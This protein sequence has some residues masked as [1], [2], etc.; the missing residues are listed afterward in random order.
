MGAVDVHQDFT[1]NDIDVLRDGDGDGVGD[2]NERLV[3]TDPDDSA[4]TPGESTVD[5]LVL[6]DKAFRD[7]Y[8]GDPY[9]R[10]HHLV[11]V[12]DEIFGRS[13]TGINLR[14]VG[15][16]E[17]EFR[18]KWHTS[19]LPEWAFVVQTAETHGG[20]MVVMLRPHTPG[21]G[22]CGWAHLTGLK[23]KG[24]MRHAKN[25]GPDRHFV[26]VLGDCSGQVLAHELGHSFG[27]VHSF[28]QNE[29]GTFRWSRGHYVDENDGL[30]IGGAGTTMSY[31]VTYDDRFFDP[32]TRCGEHACGVATTDPIKGADAVRSLQAVRFQVAAHRQAKPDSDGD[33]WVDAVDDAPDDADIWWDTDGDGINNHD[34]ADDDGDGV[35]DATDAFPID[36]TE[37]ADADGDGVGDNADAFPGDPAETKDSNDD[38]I[39]DNSSHE[40]PMFLAGG[41]VTRQGFVRIVNRSDTAGEVLVYAVDDSGEAADTVTLRIGAFEAKHFNSDDLEGGNADKGLEGRTGDGDGD[42]RLVLASRLDLVVTA[43]G[44]FS[45]FLTSL[46]DV[47]RQRE[48]GGPYLVSFFN[49]ASNRNQRSLLRIVNPGDAPAGVTITGTDDRG[50][51][52]AEE[53]RLSVPARQAVVLTSEDLES[54]SDLANGAFG[55][56]Y[57][58]WRL[59]VQADRDI[60]VM[61]L[62]RSPTGHLTNLS[63]EPYLSVPLAGDGVKF[64]LP[65]F[66]LGDTLDP[67]RFAQGFARII[68][69]DITQSALLIYAG[70]DSSGA[71]PLPADLAPEVGHTVHYNSDDIANG[72]PGKDIAAGIGYHDSPGWLDVNPTVEMR[73]LAYFRHK[74]GFLTSMHDRAPATDVC[75]EDVPA[76]SCGLRHDIAVFNPASNRNQRSYLRLLNLHLDPMTV[77]ITGTDD[78]GQV[79]GTV[80]LELPGLSGRMLPATVLESGGDDLT[81]ALGAGYGKW[82]LKLEAEGPLVAMSL[83]RSPSGHWSNLSTIPGVE[84]FTADT[85]SE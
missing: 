2:F 27:L 55:D 18:A 51:R 13:D 60:R 78:R 1:A 15:M 43:Y 28:R 54:G 25:G 21:T 45:G 53:V 71:S 3:G 31:G 39:G 7:L 52:S 41:D 68:H 63:T 40:V 30:G 73:V 17:T 50:V 85:R 33:S 36:R 4:S 8:Q 24:V 56:G 22:L 11:T 44:R 42:W 83:L 5:L 58:K 29:G 80:R 23:S 19:V 37:W 20:D 72:N 69:R 82:R 9:T 70:I 62:L 34:D 59:D 48:R 75:P 10:I 35:N 64:P 81:G 14:V 38:G 84:P 61:S 16:K 32:D 66:S 76:R 26:F 79:G 77:A 6:Y 47:V 12:S 67:D 49:P 74:D 65:L 57:G 46:H